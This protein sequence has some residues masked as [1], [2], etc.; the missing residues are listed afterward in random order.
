[1]QGG[2]E[3]ARQNDLLWQ[4]ELVLKSCNLWAPWPVQEG[5]LQT[6]VA[7]QVVVYACT[8][9]LSVQALVYCFL[10]SCCEVCHHWEAEWFVRLPSFSPHA[11]FISASYQEASFLLSV[12]GWSFSSF[13]RVWPICLLC[14][15]CGN[16]GG[17]ACFLLWGGNSRFTQ[18]L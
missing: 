11:A 12:Q 7:F 10:K 18:D 1:M 17:L 6:A 3:A 8:R 5:Y 2:K 13:L 15:C 14:G 4:S 9:S 16:N